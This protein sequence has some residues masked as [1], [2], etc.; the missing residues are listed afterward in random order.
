MT[1]TDIQAIHEI[2]A[3]IKVTRRSIDDAQSLIHRQ[4]EAVRR[5]SISLRHLITDLESRLATCDPAMGVMGN[6]PR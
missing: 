4:C 1:P 3:D 2:V 5:H 6:D